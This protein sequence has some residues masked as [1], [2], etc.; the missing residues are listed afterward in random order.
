VGRGPGPLP[1][2][3]VRR[4]RRHQR[5]RPLPLTGDDYIEL[6]PAVFRT[7]NDYRLTID[8]RTYDCKALNPYRRLDSGLRGGNK[9]W[10]VHYDPYDI[11]VVWLRD[12]RSNGW[13]PVPWVY[14]SL[15]GQPFGLALWEHARRVTTERSGPRPAGSG[16]ATRG[17]RHKR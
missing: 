3:D 1:Q 15:A 8:N 5:L 11:N 7:V 17:S 9:Q 13:I 6:L 14:R 10:E 16:D 12:H 4:P 2:R